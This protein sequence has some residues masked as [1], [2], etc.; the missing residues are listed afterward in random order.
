MMS[1]FDRAIRT[2]GFEEADG[3]ATWGGWLCSAPFFEYMTGKDFWDD[4]RGVAIET[5]RGLEVDIVVETFYLPASKQEW[6]THTTESLDAAGRFRSP[7]DGVAYIASLPDP[8]TLER[9]FSF[10]GR[11]EAVA[12]ACGRFQEELGDD[13]FLLPRLVTTRFSWYMQFGYESFLTAV[14]LYPGRIARLFAYAA[15]EA[16]LENAVRAQLVREGRLPPFFFA[17]HD[18]CG[19]GGPLISPETLRKL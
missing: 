16:R 19:R 15:E 4:P 5:Y 2:L 6:R 13:V 1:G 10:E 9:A 8:T 3:I 12:T 17:G 18:I 11:A 14:A 7:E